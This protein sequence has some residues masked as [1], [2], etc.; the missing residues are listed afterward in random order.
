MP[1][2]QKPSNYD[3]P[4]Y[5]D[6]RSV[7]W[8]RVLRVVLVL[9]IIGLLLWAGWS[10]YDRNTSRTTGTEPSGQPESTQESDGTTPTDD[11][12]NDDNIDTSND[13]T[14][15]DTTTAPGPAGDDSE[16]LPSTGG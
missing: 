4:D 7:W 9:L 5:R 12:S 15:S 14:Q 1:L 13:Q 11:S 2:F 10:L 6:S 3:D 16:V 8:R